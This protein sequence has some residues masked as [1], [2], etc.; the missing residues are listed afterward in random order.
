MRGRLLIVVAFL[1]LIVAVVAFL[2]LS[3]GGTPTTPGGGTRVPTSVAGATPVPTEV[4][5]RVVVAVQNLPRGY[6]FPETTEEL[7]QVVAIREFPE[8]SA[9]FGGFQEI[10]DLA[11]KIARTDIYREEPILD[12]KLTDDFTGLAAVG[13]DAAAVLPQPLVAVS[14]PIDRVTSVAYA[15]Q[16]GDRVDII[17]SMLFVDVD[18]AFQS[19]VPNNITLVQV[20]E[21]GIEL[22]DT[23]QGRPESTSLGFAIIGPSERQ[24]PRLVTQR[25]IQD[26]LVVYVG[27]F[28][29]NGRFLGVTQPPPTPTGQAAQPTAAPSGG[30][31][32]VPTAT[33]ARPDIITLGVTPQEAV[34]LTW[35][36]EAK[37][38][39]TLAL[40]SATNVSRE[41][42]TAVTLDWVLNEYNI[43]V[44]VKRTFTIEP[45]IRSIRQLLA[46][47]QISLSDTQSTETQPR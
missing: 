18:E 28:P 9:P 30:G 26:A 37:L 42:T 3:R 44:P 47:E 8:R 19:I 2:F 13:S 7:Q 29:R 45:A 36:V 23:I 24:R 25:T 20:G 38:P 31:T 16:Q 17:I 41:T 10:D 33:P 4:L 27:D 46:G 34:F 22:A 35:I 11:G 15:V 40:R 21:N 43:D 12:S 6:R 1:I 14:I 39:V 32:V 5:V